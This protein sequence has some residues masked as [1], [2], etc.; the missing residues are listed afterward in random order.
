MKNGIHRGARAAPENSY[1]FLLCQKAYC[2]HRG[3]LLS[4]RL[5]VWLFVSTTRYR[6]YFFFLL[7]FLRQGQRHVRHNEIYTLIMRSDFKD[8][9]YFA[10]FPQPVKE[11]RAAWADPLTSIIQLQSLQVCYTEGSSGGFFVLPFIFS[12]SLWCI[13]NQPSSERDCS[14]LPSRNFWTE[15]LSSW[16]KKKKW[17]YIFRFLNVF[18]KGQGDVKLTAGQRM[19]TCLTHD[20]PVFYSVLWR[21]SDSST[22]PGKNRIASVTLFSVL[23]KVAE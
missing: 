17:K 22:E 4:I 12:H 19:N 23:Q 1:I 18:W 21:L 7:F 15:Q 16:K 9:L 13:I 10:P 8:T 3:L 2:T 6:Y 14:L 11:L 5:S 20:L